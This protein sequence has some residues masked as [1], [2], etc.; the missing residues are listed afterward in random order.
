[1]VK[2]L[3]FACRLYQ[4][5]YERL[6]SAKV[7]AELASKKKGGDGGSPP[8][9]Y[10]RFMQVLYGLLDGSVDN[11]KFEDECRAII[12]TQSYILFTLDKLIFKLVKQLQAAATDDVV[13]KLLALN[14]YEN[15]RE[16]VDA[17]CYADACVVLHDEKI[18]RFEQRSNPTELLVQLMEHFETP[19]NSLES[20]F[21]K[22]LD[23]FLTSAPSGKRGQ[24][25]CVRN[26]KR[27]RVGEGADYGNDVNILNGL[28]IKMSCRTS[29]VS[30]VLD[31]EDVF[32]RSV[33]GGKR[34]KVTAE[35]KRRGQ[36]HKWMQEMEGVRGA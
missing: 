23:G 14:A 10:S 6:L 8:N 22:Y 32:W 17:V 7:N 28:E 30:Y 21:Q 3:V 9:L 18:Y 20:S 31:T 5:L 27:M 13:Q 2:N 36:F 26:L 33:P 19:G 25:F 24:V 29:K 12:G 1:M 15:G 34:R 16:A 11:S 4:T 35:S